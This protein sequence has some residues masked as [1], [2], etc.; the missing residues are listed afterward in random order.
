MNSWFAFYIGIAAGSIVLL[1][2]LALIL[3]LKP[4]NPNDTPEAVASPG[5]RRRARA[6]RKKKT[7]HAGSNLK[8]DSSFA[9][10]LRSAGLALSARFVVLITMVMGALL[11]VFFFTFLSWP[12]P[13]ALIAGGL[14][15]FVLL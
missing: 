12:L 2:G 15:A 11:G 1:F 5:K 3:L 14:L 9:A 6:G 7:K 8:R 13:L 4:V 10:R